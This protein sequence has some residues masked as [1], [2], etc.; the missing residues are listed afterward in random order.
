MNVLVVDCYMDKDVW[1]AAD[2]CKYAYLKPGATFHVRRAP[3]EDLPNDIS[4]FDRVV[5]SGS[6][7]SI[8]E[9]GPWIKALENFAKSVIQA[10]KPVFGICYGHQILARVL[11]GDDIVG[12]AAEP[13]FGWT[14]VSLIAKNASPMLEN[15][16]KTFYTFN[17][18]YDEVRR[19]PSEMSIVAKSDICPVQAL[20]HENLRVFGIQFHPERTLE[21]AEKKYK[22]MKK[23]GD[24]KLFR[25]A[26]KGRTLYNESIGKTLFQNFLSW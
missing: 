19:A 5:I 15:L 1:G 2:L 9:T 23:S 8:L 21:E 12:K 4:R 24:S 22:D 10:Q 11:G 3:L 26:S 14:K 6:R 13:E 20:A 25:N 16:P 18:H 7:T 17:S